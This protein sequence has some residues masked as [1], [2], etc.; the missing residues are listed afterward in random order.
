[1]DLLFF[2]LFTGNDYCSY[3]VLVPSLCMAQR[4]LS[5]VL[6]PK[7]VSLC[8]ELTQHEATLTVGWT[9][10]APRQNFR[11]VLL[12][13]SKKETALHIPSIQRKKRKERRNER[14]PKVSFIVLLPYFR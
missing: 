14:E 5:R 6:K 10:G 8:Q 4:L 1:M 13:L 7:P 9:F 3:I 2:L 12:G 11:N